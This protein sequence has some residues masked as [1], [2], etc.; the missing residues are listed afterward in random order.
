[1]P[2]PELPSLFTT[3]PRRWAVAGGGHVRTGQG[4]N[5][6]RSTPEAEGLALFEQQTGGDGTGYE[7]WKKEAARARAQTEEARRAEEL[8][9]LGS[10]AGYAAWKREAE[11]ARRSFERQ[12]GV[13]LGQAVRVQLRGERTERE[14]V[15]RVAEEPTEPGGVLRLRLGERVFEAR[16]IESLVTL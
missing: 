15:L 13:P 14:G 1:M 11:E 8:P 9:A 10:D 4:A 3:T 16:E 7:R 12:W 2:E 5:E 6:E